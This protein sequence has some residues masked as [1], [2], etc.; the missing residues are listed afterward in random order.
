MAHKDVLKEIGF[1]L[2]DC[3]GQVCDRTLTGDTNCISERQAVRTR[4]DTGQAKLRSKH[5]VLWVLGGTAFGK[6]AIR[7]CILGSP[8]A[9]SFN[10]FLISLSVS[11]L[12]AL[13]SCPPLRPWPPS[14]V[15]NFCT[16]RTDL[17]ICSDCARRF[18]IGLGFSLMPIK[19]LS[20]AS[21]WAGALRDLS[22]S[23]QTSSGI[24]AMRC[25]EA[26]LELEECWGS[27]CDPE[28]RPAIPTSCSPVPPP[29]PWALGIRPR[30]RATV[31]A[32]A[33]FPCA[34][35]VNVVRR[36]GGEPQGLCHAEGSP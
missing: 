23:C 33:S 31:C 28:L 19:L 21:L 25:A 24:D 6:R 27:D 9:H 26:T 29:P 11:A 36:G 20:G 32:P 1:I 8:F 5:L 13:R 34:V 3:H 15:T 18:R 4:Q 30:R 16:Y 14:A 7:L 10:R 35:H 2:R 22:K 12:T 17:S